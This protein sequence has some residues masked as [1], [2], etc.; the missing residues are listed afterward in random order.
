MD[1]FQTQT[2]SHSFTQTQ[3][4]IDDAHRDRNSFRSL[5]RESNGD[6]VYPEDSN[7]TTHTYATLPRYIYKDII[8]TSICLHSSTQTRTLAFIITNLFWKVESPW[9]QAADEQLQIRLTCFWS[10]FISLHVFPVAHRLWAFFLMQSWS[11]SLHS[12]L[13]LISNPFWIFHISL[14]VGEI[15]TK[16]IATFMQ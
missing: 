8:R 12:Y 7:P 4:W 13:Q 6:D 10:V 5:Q 9:M 1:G 15:H 16:S 3:M 11:A 14:S 2:L